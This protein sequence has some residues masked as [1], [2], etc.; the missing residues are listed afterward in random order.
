MRRKRTNKVPNV[1]ES[2]KGGIN[3]ENFTSSTQ[4]LMVKETL[5]YLVK[6]NFSQFHTFAFHYNKTLQC[7]AEVIDRVKASTINSKKN[8]KHNISNMSGVNCYHF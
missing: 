3:L 2:I 7:I 5:K 6:V 4:N 1:G 8:S